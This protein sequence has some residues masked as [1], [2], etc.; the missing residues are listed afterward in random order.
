M[1][2]ISPFDI[3][4]GGPPPSGPGGGPPGMPPRGPPPGMAGARPPG[5]PPRPGAPGM[6]PGMP[7]GAPPGG[8]P[9]RQPPPRGPPQAPP[10]GG[11]PTMLYHTY[12]LL[13]P[14]DDT[15]NERLML[16]LSYTKTRQDK[17]NNTSFTSQCTNASHSIS[18]PPDFLSSF[19]S[20][21]ICT[22]PPLSFLFHP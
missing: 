11:M 2:V 8:G 21:I 13:I 4:L 1:V 15:H 5:G 6:P 20:L 9:P 18:L 10:R 12:T 7:M 19:L 3:F 16:I 14:M 22:F 17:H